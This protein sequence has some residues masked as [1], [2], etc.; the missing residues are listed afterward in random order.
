MVYIKTCDLKYVCS[1]SGF[2][3]PV[4]GTC[5]IGNA[6]RIVNDTSSLLGNVNTRM[7]VLL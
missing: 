1:T 5:S 4:Y 7:L 3:S 6:M 2:A